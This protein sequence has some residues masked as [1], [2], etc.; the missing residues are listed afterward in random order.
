MSF[1]S[2]TRRIRNLLVDSSFILPIAYA[3]WEFQGDEVFVSDRLKQMLSYDSNFVDPYDFVKLMQKSFGSFLQTALKKISQDYTDKLYYSSTINILGEDFVLKLLFNQ[4]KQF[5]LLLIDNAKKSEIK[6]NDSEL[7]KILDALPVYVWQKDKDL[8]ITYCNKAYASAVEST[9][10][11]V[12]A[13]NIKLISPSRKDSIYV[14]QS[15]YSSKPKKLNERVVI[16]GERRLLQITE[17]PFIADNLSTGIAIDITDKEELQKEYDRYKKQT[18]ETL[19]NISVPIAIFD[20]KT[21]LVFANEAMIKLFSVEGLDLYKNCKFSD[22]I[23]HF[24]SN[25]SII[26]VTDAL[27]YKG[28]VTKLFSTIVEPYHASVNLRNGDTMSVTISPNRGGGL[29]FMFEDISDRVA[30]KR[31]VSSISAV[32]KETLDHLKE[33]VVV[34]GSDNRAKITNPSLDLQLLISRLISMFEQ[35]KGFSDTMTLSSGKTI[36][37]S[38]VPLPAGLNLVRF[39]DVTDSAN[40]EKILKEKTEIVSQISKLKSSLVANISYEVAAP[41]NTITGFSEILYNKY[42]GDLNEKQ[43]EY[44]RGIMKSIEGLTEVVDAVISLAKIDSEQVRLKYEEVNLL[45]FINNIIELFATRAMVENI[46]LKTDF[47][48]SD[49]TVFIDETSMR[50]AISQI[51]SKSIKM[52]PAKGKIIISAKIDKSNENYFDLIIKDT[53][54]GFSEEELDKLRKVLSENVEIETS[55]TPAEFG[56]TLANKIIKLHNG[57]MSIDSVKGKGTTISCKVPIRQFLQ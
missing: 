4:D 42:F 2:N 26:A 40:L 48:D 24:L 36:N 25:G 19:D 44:C 3:V 17:T 54:V 41:L 37:Y 16:N 52:T 31:E 32:Q 6:K 18:E 22:L 23:D 30:L 39:L 29:I 38:Y 47:K 49:I 11:Y 34:F 53:S 46:E 9:R 28:K 51:I 35:R 43:M 20:E 50:Q 21:V 8:K 57:N 10:D 56:L 12:V 14:D 7:E 15:L 27:E 1:E 13:N 5:Y 45:S 33:G 55:D